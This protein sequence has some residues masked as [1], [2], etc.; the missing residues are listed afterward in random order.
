V[1]IYKHDQSAHDADAL[2]SLPSE[3][4]QADSARR[5]SGVPQV[6]ARDNKKPASKPYLAIKQKR[7][8]A[9][10][11]VQEHSLTWGEIKRAIDFALSDDAQIEFIDLGPPCAITVI[12]LLTGYAIQGRRKPMPP[13]CRSCGGEK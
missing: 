5:A 2:P 7:T 11:N 1:R 13:S 10:V 12:K 3:V 8:R 6:L 4:S 9:K